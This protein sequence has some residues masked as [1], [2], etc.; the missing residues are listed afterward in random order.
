MSDLFGGDY[1]SGLAALGDTETV[2]VDAVNARLQVCGWATKDVTVT[3]SSNGDG[4]YTI[5]ISDC[6]GVDSLKFSC[7]GTPRLVTTYGDNPTFVGSKTSAWRRVVCD[8]RAASSG[9]LIDTF[10]DIA[11]GVQQTAS[12]TKPVVA[13]PATTIDPIRLSEED[14]NQLT[15]NYPQ[16]FMRSQ[17]AFAPARGAAAATRSTPPSGITSSFSQDVSAVVNSITSL[18]TPLAAARQ[19]R[20]QAAAARRG[21]VSPTADRG[22]GDNTTTYLVIGGGVLLLAG[23]L[24]VVTGD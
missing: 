3:I 12:T 10:S 19:Q 7:N 24:F 21:R 1:N 2:S 14:L 8:A 23:L 6:H 15:Q 17:A 20:T 11:K 9:T 4:T 5:A 22:G 16:Q 13:A 18:V